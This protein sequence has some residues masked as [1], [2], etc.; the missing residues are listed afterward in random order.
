MNDRERT[1]SNYVDAIEVK[2]TSLI[3]LGNDKTYNLNYVSF[4]LIRKV[5]DKLGYQINQTYPP[6]GWSADYAY[7]IINKEH[8]TIWFIEGSLWY[9][10]LKLT[11]A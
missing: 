3:L 7:V 5:C 8:K 1:I 11:K 6:E 4:G 9:G 2:L 10:E